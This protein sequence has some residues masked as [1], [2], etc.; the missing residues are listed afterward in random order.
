VV[1]NGKRVL[2]PKDEEN[3]D[4]SL[5]AVVGLPPDLDLEG[6]SLIEAMGKWE[7]LDPRA[8]AVLFRRAINFEELGSTLTAVDLVA[9]LTLPD[10]VVELSRNAW[11]KVG[12]GSYL[13]ACGSSNAEDLRMAMLSC[14]ALGFYDLT[15]S[16]SSRS[17]VSFPC[18]MDLP[19]AFHLADKK[20]K[21][22]WPF[23]GGFTMS[24][25]GWRNKKISTEQ[26]AEL[27]A[28]GVG[29]TVLAMLE[30]AGQAWTFLELTRKS[31]LGALA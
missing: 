16:S 18:G 10:E 12:D 17:P 20:I 7:K 25:A 27:R 19:R 26:R 15:L 22:I 1:D 29:D 3:N 13:L 4:P 5:A 28:L 11:M 31:R 9:E 30:T 21:E 24:V 14:D 2:A 8:Q 6:H 23:T